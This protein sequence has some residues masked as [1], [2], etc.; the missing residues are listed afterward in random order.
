MQIETSNGYENIPNNSGSPPAL[1]S[2]PVINLLEYALKLIGIGV[3]GNLWASKDIANANQCLNMLLAQWQQNGYLSPCRVDNFCLSTGNIKTFIGPGGDIDIPIRPSQ[4]TACYCRLMYS[5][6]K[7]NGETNTQEQQE[8]TDQFTGQFQN[9][10]GQETDDLF[11][12]YPLAP[13][14]SYEEYSRI[15]IKQLKTFPRYFFYN[16]TFPLGTL[17]V[18]PVPRLRYFQIHI[19]YPEFLNGNIL[20]NTQLSLPPE[21]WKAVVYTLAL[22]LG[23]LYGVTSPQTELI[24]QIAK[25]AQEIVRNSN[26]R[27]D[28]S[29]LPECCDNGRHGYASINPA[30]FIS[31]GWAR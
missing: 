16:P 26:L 9:V 12:D 21:Y 29:L 8:F 13:L 24:A 25:N 27:L 28:E 6:V 19:V 11:I 4:I 31:G 7:E 17:Y 1:N 18:Y 3:T 15:G 22:E 30:T 5:H 14:A 23:I 20:L 2:Y 10:N